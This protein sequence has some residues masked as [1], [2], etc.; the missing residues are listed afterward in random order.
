MIIITL[1]KVIKHKFKLKIKK[2]RPA[3]FDW[4]EIHIADLLTDLRGP[5]S[6]KGWKTELNKVRVG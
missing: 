1:S 6:D 3:E 4:P 2:T 5:R